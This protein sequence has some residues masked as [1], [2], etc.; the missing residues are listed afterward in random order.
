VLALRYIFKRQSMIH[1][2]HSQL[3][4]GEDTKLVE[5]IAEVVLHRIPGDFEAL[6]NFAVRIPGN[7]RRNYVQLALSQIECFSLRFFVRA[8]FQVEQVLHEIRNAHSAH[9]VLAI[10]HGVDAPQQKL[11]RRV[12]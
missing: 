12:L 9:P 7:N 4:A 6:R 10:H 8:P 1:R 11:R 3:Q 5:D 2:E